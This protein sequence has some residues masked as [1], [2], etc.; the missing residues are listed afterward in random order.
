ML[1]RQHSLKEKDIYVKI[2]LKQR[3]NITAHPK[4]S[5]QTLDH[6]EL[7]QE[8][9]QWCQEPLQILSTQTLD[10]LKQEANNIVRHSW[11]HSRTLCVIV[12]YYYY[13]FKLNIQYI[14]K[15][16]VC[17]KEGTYRS[18]MDYRELNSHKNPTDAAGSPTINDT[19]INDWHFSYVAN[20]CSTDLSVKLTT[21]NQSGRY[22]AKRK[23]INSG[24]NYASESTSDDSPKS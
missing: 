12:T 14:D 13:F 20:Y 23:P 5:T 6:L 15:K 19:T 24:P 18:C 4:F 7:V 8:A 16:S 22:T 3:R 10:H 9:K 17:K 11:I 2:M 1:E 21:L